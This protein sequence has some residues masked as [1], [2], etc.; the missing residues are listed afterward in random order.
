MF[1]LQEVIIESHDDLEIW[2]SVTVGFDDDKNLVILLKH[3]D[4][5]DR[6]NDNN[7]YVIVDK[8]EAITLSRRLKVGIT[9]LPKAI[10]DRYGDTSNLSVSSHVEAVFKEIVE[11]I[12]DHRI[13]YSIKR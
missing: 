7:T 1:E 13:H 10:F 9:T 4:Y 2:A 12:N 11:F 6:N 3:I 5:E 8:E